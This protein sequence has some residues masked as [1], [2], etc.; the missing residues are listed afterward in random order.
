MLALAVGDV[1]I[2]A[3]WLLVHGKGA[4]ECRVP[5]DT[6][7]AATIQTYLLIERPESTS[8]MLFLVAKGKT[9]GRPLTPAGLRTGRCPRCS[10]TGQPRESVPPRWT[11]RTSYGYAPTIDCVVP[12]TSPEAIPTAEHA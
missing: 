10:E 11:R 4:K 2:G 7:V 3:R 12:K 1:D 6:D 9:R 5:L 8:P